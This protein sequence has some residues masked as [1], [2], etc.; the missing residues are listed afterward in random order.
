MLEQ[1]EW[2][3]EGLSTAALEQL[4]EQFEKQMADLQVAVEL[5][6]LLMLVEPSKGALVSGLG[7]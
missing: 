6:V 5:T 4:G 2:Q 3:P 7:W 1:F